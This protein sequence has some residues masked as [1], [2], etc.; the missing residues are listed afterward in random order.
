MA[1]ARLTDSA[2]SDVLAILA[3]THEKFGEDARKRY[4]TLIVTAVQD[5][6]SLGEVGGLKW[7]PELG[8]GVC[9]WHFS[10]SRA[11]TS[12][13]AV[14]RPRHVLI[15]RRDGDELVVG[16]I[17]HDTMDLERHVDPGRTW[18]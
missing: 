7:R 10:N 5:A 4:E 9:S 17:L 15:C 3:W 12:G 18:E 14:A 13:A 1:V 8:A 16:R 2:Q 11:R 6:A